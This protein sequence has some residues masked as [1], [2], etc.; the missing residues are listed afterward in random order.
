MKLI[1]LLFLL[2]VLSVLQ[3]AVHAGW[4]STTSHNPRKTRA[5]ED[6]GADMTQKRQPRGAQATASA[7]ATAT[8]ASST[9][10]GS[11]DQ[12][13]RASTSTS[14]EGARIRNNLTRYIHQFVD[15]LDSD[16]YDALV[17]REVLLLLLDKLRPML[18]ESSA[19]SSMLE[20]GELTKPEFVKHA[21]KHALEMGGPYIAEIVSIF[22]DPRKRAAVLEEVPAKHRHLAERLLSGATGV[23]DGLVE[24]VLAFVP[25]L[26][27]HQREMLR[28]M[29]SGN[30]EEMRRSANHLFEE[31]NEVENTRLSLLENPGMVEL[32]GIED[33]ILQDPEMFAWFMRE[34]MEEAEGS[35]ERSPDSDSGVSERG[36]QRL[37]QEL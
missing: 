14:I 6:S 11:D 1:L 7:A 23:S 26:D 37:F 35:G 30:T 20:A 9:H 31:P 21:L 16:L 34:S 29:A 22:E 5:F 28:S 25:N 18:L 10:L 15:F 4:D 19:M 17:T 33:S 8:A 24:F 36:T 12:T 32:L 2:V 13:K 27:V 3:V